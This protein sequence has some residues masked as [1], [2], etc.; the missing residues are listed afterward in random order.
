[1]LERSSASDAARGDEKEPT[2]FLATST[3]GGEADLEELLPFLPISTSRDGEW[4][5]RRGGV[6]SVLLECLSASDAAVRVGEDA[7]RFLATLASSTCSDGEAGGEGVVVRSVLLKSSSEPNTAVRDGEDADAVRF[8][9]A[10]ASSTCSD[11]E[12]GGGV[13][14]RSVF[15]KSSSE[16]NSAV[17]DGEEG[18]GAPMSASRR[19][20]LS[21]IPES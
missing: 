5:R 10:L 17:R 7:V 12:W 20:L 16:P 2:R 18:A 1:M 6:S 19:L 3:G 9:G 15:L 4:R 11:G 14:V 21:I 8:L 13:A